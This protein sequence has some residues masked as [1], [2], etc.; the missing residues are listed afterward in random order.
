[1]TFSAESSAAL[2]ANALSGDAVGVLRT[3]FAAHA[4]D[5]APHP[6]DVRRGLALQE[7]IES[8]FAQLRSV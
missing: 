6:L 4:R 8:G 3:E 1:M 5:A 7:L 2:D